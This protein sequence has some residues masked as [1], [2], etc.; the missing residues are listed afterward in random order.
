MLHVN[1]AVQQ[2]ERLAV[3]GPSGA[4]KTTIVELVSRFYDATEGTVRIGGVDVRDLDYDD[5]LAH[6]A[7][8]FQKTFLTSG[9]ILENIRMGKRATLD[10]VRE[11]ARQARI[12][13]FIMGLPRDYDTEIGT[14]GERLSAG[15]ASASPSPAPSSMTRPCSSRRGHQRGR[16]E[17]QLQIAR[18]SPPLPGRTVVIVAHRLGVVRTCE[19][20]AVVE[21]GG[22][23]P[24]GRTT[25]CLRVPVLPQGMADYERTRRITFGFG[26]AAR[27]SRGSAPQAIRPP[28]RRAAAGRIVSAAQR[29]RARP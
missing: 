2:G 6:V 1:L 11:A 14:L 8:V 10:E 26:A 17:N 22:I 16:P 21:D 23:S 20:V 19:R 25:R 28:C 18:P 9:S 27:A 4:G 3:V 15:S 12:D 13:D 24:W 7:V 29:P 5:L